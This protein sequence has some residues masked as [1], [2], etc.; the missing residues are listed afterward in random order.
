M[1]L[2]NPIVRNVLAIISGLVAGSLVNMGLINIGPSVVPLPEGAD[3][4]TT[5]SFRES[6]KLFAPVNFL[7]PFLAHAMGTLSGAFITARIAASR[8]LMQAMVIGVFF[9]IGGT[10]MVNMVG[11]PMWFNVTDLGLAYIPMAYLGGVFGRGIK[12]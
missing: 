9:L 5:E 4:S 10:M 1:L 8:Q 3:M 12:T 2:M 7:F 11:G 6:I